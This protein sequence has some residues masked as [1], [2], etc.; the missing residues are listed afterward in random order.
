VTGASTLP[1]SLA[2]VPD[3]SLAG[4]LLRLSFRLGVPPGLVAAATGLIPRIGTIPA[5]RMLVLGEAS[6][7]AFAEATRLGPGEVTALTLVGRP[8]SPSTSPTCAHGP[9]A[10]ASGG[11]SSPA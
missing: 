9:A 1:R 8:P 5:S 6:T 4:Y 7:G 3:E 11:E 2:P 10:T